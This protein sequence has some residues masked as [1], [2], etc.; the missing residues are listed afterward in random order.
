LI[1][2]EVVCVSIGYLCICRIKLTIRLE[3]ISCC[4]PDYTSCV[5]EDRDAR[6]VEP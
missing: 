6:W 1:G 4:A 2:G 5:E 3:H